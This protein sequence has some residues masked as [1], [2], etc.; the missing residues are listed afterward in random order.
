MFFWDPTMIWL[1]PP[2]LF[3]LYAQ[4]KVRSAYRKFSQIRSTAGLTGAQIATSILRENGIHDVEIEET[5]GTLSDHYDPRSRTVRLSNTNYRGS[6]IASLSVA[7]H[8]V[9]HAI[10]HQSDYYPLS[11]R[12]SILPFANLGSTLAMPLFFIGFFFQFPTLI[13][14]GI[15]FFIGAVLF[16]VVTLPVEFNASSR[17]L[18]QL[19]KGGYLDSSEISQAKKVLNAAALTYIAAAA[20]SVFHLIRLLI[21]RNAR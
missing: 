10:Q 2:M 9:G 16:Q 20:V 5:S 15:F 14:V 6:S 12:H 13:D 18:L 17:A 11:I 3:A 1:I 4:N 7:A 21:L 8:E 19:E